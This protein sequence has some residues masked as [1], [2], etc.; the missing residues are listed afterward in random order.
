MKR[1][2]NNKNRAESVLSAVIT[3]ALVLTLAITVVSAM[4]KGNSGDNNNIVD[5]NETNEQNMQL[6]NEELTTAAQDKTTAPQESLRPD[7]ENPTESSTKNS[8][9]T[10][11]ENPGYALAEDPADISPKESTK[12]DVAV[13]AMDSVKSNLSFS[14]NS[15][16]YWPVVGDVILKYNMDNTIWFPT[17]GVYKCNPEIYI[18]C[19]AGTK[20]TSS[21]S[22]VVDSITQDEENGTS[23]VLSIGNG[24]TLTY[25]AV[26]NLQVVK[27]DLVKTGETIGY[28]AEPT[29]YYSA[30][31]SGLHFKVECDGEPVDPMLFLE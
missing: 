17:L 15:T 14:E 20:I 16:L 5:L 6:N 18:S 4:R 29:I 25:G 11:Q 28:V 27:G 7:S 3:A 22:G 19:D 2:D 30:E 26:D 8:L 9:E 1:Q 24:Y 13:D 31:G 10:P 23:V 21:C 12:S